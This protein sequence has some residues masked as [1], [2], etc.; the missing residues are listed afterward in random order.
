M[1]LTEARRVLMDSFGVTDT[2]NLGKTIMCTMMAGKTAPLALYKEKIEIEQDTLQAIY[3]YDLADRKQAKQDFTPGS[4]CRLLAMLTGNGGRTVYDLCAGS[5]ALTIAKWVQNPNRQFI[6]EERDEGVL[7]YLLANLALRNMEA[8]VIHRDALTLQQNAV[9]T[10][11]PGQKI[12]SVKCS[13]ETPEI[14]ADEIISNPPFNVRWEPPAPLTADDRFFG[15]PIPP[16]SSANFA[17]VMTAAHRLKLNGRAAIILPCGILNSDEERDVRQYLIEN[18]LIE[19]VILLPGGMFETTNIP[20]C[21]LVLSHGNQAVKM[22]DLRQRGEQVQRDQ[23]G[24]YGGRSKT[25]RVYTKTINVLTD[26]TIASVCGTCETCPG[27]SRDVSTQE[28]AEN[29]FWLAPS[30]YIPFEPQETAH[31]PYADIIAD[32]NRVARERSILKITVNETLAK[33]VGLY[34]VAQL[35]GTKN[36]AEI[37]KLFAALGSRYAGRRYITLTRSRE[38]KVENQD[39]EIWSHLLMFFLPMWKQHI[40]Y[41][42]LEENR[43]LAELRDAMLPDLMSGKL[44]AEDLTKDTGEKQEGQA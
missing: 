35:E 8:V 11:H 38:F 7:P 36:D 44:N 31:R 18:G 43:L 32:I 41:L 26:E 5:G 14:Q 25:G 13:N 23:R 39:K 19:R 24:Q 3:Q 9:Y 6:C 30:Q 29:G 40:Y 37:D 42:N 4:L 22:Y 17:F 15:K 33:D 21:V 27:F 34:E 10:L 28:I 20:T 16:A 2:R 12:A 1:E